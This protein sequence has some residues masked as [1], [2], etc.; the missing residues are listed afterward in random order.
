MLGKT[1]VESSIYLYF[2]KWSNDSTLSGIQKKNLIHTHRP[3]G[4]HDT[5][6][7]Q[8][9]TQER[10]DK[11]TRPTEQMYSNYLRHTEYGNYQRPME[12]IDR[13]LRRKVL[14]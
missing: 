2:L 10:K 12:W 14:K 13:N 11:N 5:A 6:H 4:W 3:S 7:N 1:A 9:F 8:S